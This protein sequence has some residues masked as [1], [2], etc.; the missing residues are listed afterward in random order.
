MEIEVNYSLKA[1]LQRIL[2]ST[3]IQVDQ[4]YV[5]VI[6]AHP[7]FEFYI[8]RSCLYTQKTLIVIV[9]KDTFLDNVKYLATKIA[10]AL[11]H[12]KISIEVTG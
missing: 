9:A 12:Q 1:R 5:T 8:P 4:G 3:R 11:G 6:V 10:E 2:P 7:Q